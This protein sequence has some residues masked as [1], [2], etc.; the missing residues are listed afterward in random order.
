[1]TPLPQLGRCRLRAPGPRDDPLRQCA[2]QVPVRSSAAAFHASA[3][4]PGSDPT[5]YRDGRPGRWSRDPGHSQQP[6]LYQGPL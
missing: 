5:Q 3:S 1:M 2:R 6:P 4:G